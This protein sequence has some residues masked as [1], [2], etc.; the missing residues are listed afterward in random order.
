[1]TP[2]VI[3]EEALKLKPEE[4]LILIEGV[5]MSLDQPDIK[6]DEIWADEA[7]KRL[8]AY[9]NGNLQGIPMEE[10]FK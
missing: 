5:I 6:I 1:M 8:T 10:I 9:R 3:L 4:K 2:K 7:H